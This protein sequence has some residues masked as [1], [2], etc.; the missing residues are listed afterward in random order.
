MCKYDKDYVPV[1]DG[2]ALRVN[3][4]FLPLK[5]SYVSAIRYT[6]SLLHTNFVLGYEPS[7]YGGIDV[8][9]LDRQQPA[10]EFE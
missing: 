9:D 3:L 4:M 2:K 7:F 6:L 5:W 1:Q 10:M 8:Y